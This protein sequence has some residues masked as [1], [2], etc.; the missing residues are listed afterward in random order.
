MLEFAFEFSSFDEVYGFSLEF[1]V[2]DFF[3]LEKFAFLKHGFFVAVY[4]QEFY[5]FYQWLMVGRINWSFQ[6]MGQWYVSFVLLFS[7]LGLLAG[8]FQSFAKR[9]FK[10]VYWGRLGGIVTFWSW[11]SVVM[12]WYFCCEGGFLCHLFFF[13]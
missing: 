1:L 5:S 2:F 4:F 10:G 12:W 9:L 8:L 6:F 11:W 13:S 3:G 7:F